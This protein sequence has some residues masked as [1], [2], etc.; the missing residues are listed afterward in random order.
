F[1]IFKCN[2]V[3]YAAYSNKWYTMDPKVAE[4]LLLLMTRG[5]KQ[6]CL[7]VGKMSPVTMATFCSVRYFNI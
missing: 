4:D 2:K 3:Y 5:S 6:I 1:N 7:T